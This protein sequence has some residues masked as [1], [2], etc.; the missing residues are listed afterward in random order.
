M[1]RIVNRFTELLAIKRRNEGKPWNYEE[2]SRRT[3]LSTGTLVRYAKQDHSMFDENTVL[4]LCAFF[5]CE[6]GDLLIIQP[7]APEDWITPDVN[8]KRDINEMAPALTS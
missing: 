7:D 3:G 6:I 4:R 2:V 5:N 1:A 8:E